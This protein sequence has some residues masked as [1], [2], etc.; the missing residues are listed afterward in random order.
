MESSTAALKS[1]PFCSVCAVGSGAQ[2]DAPDVDGLARGGPH[3]GRTDARTHRPRQGRPQPARRQDPGPQRAHARRGC[4]QGRL[5]RYAN[6]KQS[7]LGFG[8]LGI[9]RI[10]GSLRI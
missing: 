1:K 4:Q 3:R 5:S 2:A 6:L 9:P 8:A 7:P 10:R